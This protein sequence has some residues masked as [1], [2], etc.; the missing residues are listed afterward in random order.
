M[1]IKLKL[2]TPYEYARPAGLF[3]YA[4]Q[5]SKNDHIVSLHASRDMADAIVNALNKG[6]ISHFSDGY[7]VREVY[8]GEAE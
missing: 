8:E 7:L 3:K 6:Q 2:E 4:I 1:N 5:S